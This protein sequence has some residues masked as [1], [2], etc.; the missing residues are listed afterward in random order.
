MTQLDL[1]ED[2][3]RNWDIMVLHFINCL[4]LMHSSEAAYEAA[5]R[6]HERVVLAMEV[7]IQLL[8]CWE[9]KAR[10]Q[11]S[12]AWGHFSDNLEYSRQAGMQTAGCQVS[13]S[14]G[15]QVA[16]GNYTAHSHLHTNQ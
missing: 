1:Q 7:G 3:Q 12:R 6:K 5:N 8:G 9:K 2:I 4:L 14:V 13:A 10:H 16:G 15:D 11:V